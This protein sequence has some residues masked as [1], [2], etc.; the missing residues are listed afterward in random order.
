MTSKYLLELTIV[1]GTFDLAL[2]PGMHPSLFVET[3]VDSL[4]VPA[5]NTDLVKMGKQSR[6]TWNKKLSLEFNNLEPPT[7]VIIAMSVFRKR[8]IHKGCKL[9]GT[10]RFSTAELI[11]LLNKG[12]VQRKVKIHMA[13]HIPATGTLSITLN[14]RIVNPMGLMKNE[15][16]TGDGDI[17]DQISLNFSRDKARTVS[18]VLLVLLVAVVCGFLYKRLV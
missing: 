1:D 14:L 10:A 4:V 9:V 16:I 3:T 13:K 18:I 17:L 8:R 6:T 2:P 7:P 11:P 15:S 12:E 5:N